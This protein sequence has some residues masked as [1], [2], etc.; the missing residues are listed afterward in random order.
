MCCE[1]DLQIE[2]GKTAGREAEILHKG[3]LYEGDVE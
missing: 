1:S 3:S 2:T